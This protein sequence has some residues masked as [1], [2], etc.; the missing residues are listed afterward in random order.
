MFGSREV[1][2]HFRFQ[3]KIG[4]KYPKARVKTETYPAFSY[5]LP[6][7][8]SRSGH[9]FPNSVTKCIQQPIRPSWQ[10]VT[11]QIRFNA[12]AQQNPYACF[13]VCSLHRDLMPGWTHTT[14]RT[15]LPFHQ[16][17]A[18]V[19]FQRMTLSD[20]PCGESCRNLFGSFTARC[21]QLF[22]L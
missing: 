16:P 10:F 17:L 3:G 8:A 9:G 21:S 4:L 19:T 12:H 7:A 14:I 5:S 15:R 6:K 22:D 2:A 18:L 20:R 1:E 11:L 13:L